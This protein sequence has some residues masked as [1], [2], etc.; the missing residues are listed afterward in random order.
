MMIS[1]T[2]ESKFMHHFLALEFSNKRYQFIYRELREKKNYMS[3]NIYK[4]NF[5]KFHMIHCIASL[6]KLNLDCCNSQSNYCPN[7]TFELLI[8]SIK[9]TIDKYKKV[10]ANTSNSSC[11]ID[12]NSQASYSHSR[13]SLFVTAGTEG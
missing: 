4:V 9:S 3:N 11:S 7:P 1:F 13:Y 5:I 10:C 2:S 12:T 8:L 6:N